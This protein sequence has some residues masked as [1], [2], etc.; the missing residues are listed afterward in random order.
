MIFESHSLRE[1]RIKLGP[2]L[3]SWGHATEYSIRNSFNNLRLTRNLSLGSLFP[4]MYLVKR[5]TRN[6]LKYLLNITTILYLTALYI[7]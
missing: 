4:N 2:I 7:F 3:K 6:Y 1:T 5:V